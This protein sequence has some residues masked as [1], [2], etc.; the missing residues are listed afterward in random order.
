MLALTN[1]KKSLSERGICILE[2]TKFH[3]ESTPTDPFGAT[4]E[5][6]EEMLKTIDVNLIKI[7]STNLK[8]NKKFIV[9]KQ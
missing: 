5:E 9:F 2:H 4:L 6:Y 1:W 8:H 3:E 7:Y